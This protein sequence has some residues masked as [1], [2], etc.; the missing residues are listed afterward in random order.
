MVHMLQA[1]GVYACDKSICAHSEDLSSSDESFCL[2]V[3][4]QHTQADCKKIPVSSHLI[5]NLEYRLKPPH[6]R[7][8]YLGAR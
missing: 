7:N 6:T 8:Q 2:Q 3:M 4:I 1:G 5:T